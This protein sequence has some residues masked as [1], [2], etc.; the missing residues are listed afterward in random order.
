MGK[1]S[2]KKKIARELSKK[3]VQKPHKQKKEYFKKT[4][5]AVK[6]KLA[7]VKQVNKR[8]LFG[9]LL[10][11]I[12]LTILV[13]VGYLIFNKAFRPTPVEKYL[14]AD[15][16]VMVLSVNVNPQHNQFIK[17]FELLKNYP[18]YSFDS[19]VKMIEKDY[20]INYEK[21]IK[22]WLGREA[23]VAFVLPE[24]N[25][26]TVDKFYFAEMISPK[27]AEIAM[28]GSQ[29]STYKTYTVYKLKDKGFAVFVDDYLFFSGQESAI[30]NLLDFQESSEKALY[31]AQDFSRI[32][33]NL[34]IIRMGFIYLA[35][36]KINDGFFKEIPFLSE[37]GIASNVA[38]P[39]LKLFKSEGFVFVA[40]ENNFAVESFTNLNVNK[41]KGG[42]YITFKQKYNAGLS[43][44]VSEN[45]LAFWGGQNLEYQIK[46]IEEILSGGDEGTML[47]FDEILKNYVQR[48]FGDG[49]NI[50]EDIMAIFKNEFALTIENTNG[51]NIYKLLIELKDPR[52]DAL[53][54]QK[55]A[56]DFSKMGGFIKPKIVEH[57]L[58]DGTIAREIVA[59]PG[60]I[61]ETQEVYKDTTIYEY[62]MGEKNWGVFY[63]FINDIAVISNSVDGAKNVIDIITG[64][65]VSLRRSKLFD[66]DIKPVLQSSD[67][68]TYLNLE[69]LLPILFGDNAIPEYL[70]P[71]E[72]L[73]RGKNYF[74]DG[75]KTINYLRVK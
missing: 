27:N 58:L 45:T 41:I 34:P 15:R 17:T 33:D 18:Q 61:E 67:E 31:S 8:R 22:S 70:V 30:K 71:V 13:S 51:E 5:A 62:K 74:N 73:S 43:D 56:A 37:K 10:A 60:Q 3:E 12:M 23:G 50:K 63:S 35:L 65:A 72:S 64:N 1:K 25:A 39:L 47:I 69:K 42:E 28:N 14:P 66:T 21:Q 40:L 24:K 54:I 38:Y 11:L 48:Y 16:T 59:D 44:Y 68:I 75:V 46:R 52:N 26:L 6:E 57:K 49:V 36:D 53:K 29:K 4:K 20:S 7:I 2:K 55:L 9:G 32:N 19:F